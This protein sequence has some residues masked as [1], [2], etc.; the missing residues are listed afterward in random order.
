MNLLCALQGHKLGTFCR[1]F[2]IHYRYLCNDTVKISFDTVFCF[3]C[4]LQ[5]FLCTDL[6]CLDVRLNLTLSALIH[7]GGLGRILLRFHFGFVFFISGNQLTVFINFFL[8][9]TQFL[10]ILLF[11]GII[12]YGLLQILIGFSIPGI[13]LNQ[14]YLQKCTFS[15][16]SRFLV[17]QPAFQNLQIIL[18]VCNLLFQN[19]QV[20]ICFV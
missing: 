5:S 6:F 12:L 3:F 7:N 16:K 8:D 2:T 4:I 15:G 17:S 19:R 13:T 20:H 9:L 10:V 14:G 1:R 11:I 18:A